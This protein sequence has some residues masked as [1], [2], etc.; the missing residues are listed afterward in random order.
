ME[1]LLKSFNLGFLLRSVFSGIF[2]VVS[3]YVASNDHADFTQICD[4]T[5]LRIVLPVAL[6]AGVTTY[7]IHRSLLYP[8]FEFGFDTQ[9]CKNWRKRFSLISDS[10]IQ[11]LMWRWDQPR[12]DINQIR[13]NQHMNIWADYIH[14]QFNS[15]NCII[16]GALVAR[17]INRGGHSP[18]CPLICLTFILYVAALVSNWRHHS[19]LDYVRPPPTKHSDAA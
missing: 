15:A 13:I 1:S 7:G 19:L 8:L 12:K 18:Y 6:F 5:V 9:C 3:Y 17:A 16:A 14:L 2:F 4:K 10:T 11:T